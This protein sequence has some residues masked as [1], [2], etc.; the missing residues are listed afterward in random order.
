[1][2]II[3]TEIGTGQITPHH[4]KYPEETVPCGGR[5]P[6]NPSVTLPVGAIVLTLRGAIPVQY[7]RRGDRVVTRSGGSPLKRLYTY[8]GTCYTL[9]FDKP[10][11]V[12]VLDEEYWDH[13]ANVHH[14]QQQPPVHDA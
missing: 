10:E 2:S 13:N 12:Y 6:K 5:E 4:V 3:D 11:V 7:V 1:M 14:V 9:E 8:G